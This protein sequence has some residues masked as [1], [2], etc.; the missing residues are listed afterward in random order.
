MR[1]R[2]RKV[3]LRSTW[4]QVTPVHV[5]LLC[6]S[7]GVV[8]KQVLT[9]MHMFTSPAEVDLFVMLMWPARAEPCILGGFLSV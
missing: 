5:C 6:H 9:V 1:R 2:V 7:P 3:T 8:L 4:P